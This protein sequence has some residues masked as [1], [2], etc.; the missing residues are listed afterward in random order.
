MEYI[1]EDGSKKN[2][3]LDKRE[4][5]SLAFEHLPGMQ[6]TRKRGQAR[7]ANRFH[8]TLCHLKVKYSEETRK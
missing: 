5:L 7:V 1:N 6:V 2:A 3:A 8:M 4:K